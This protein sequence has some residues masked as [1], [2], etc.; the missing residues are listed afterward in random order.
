MTSSIAWLSYLIHAETRVSV[1]SEV[2]NFTTGGPPAAV[3][4]CSPPPV[5]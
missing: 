3:S 1:I 2:T 4:F 5:L